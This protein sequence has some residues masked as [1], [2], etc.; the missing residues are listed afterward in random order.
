[1]SVHD[2]LAKYNL[3][4]NSRCHILIC[5]KCHMGI[6]VKEVRGHYKAENDSCPWTKDQVSEDLDEYN[7]MITSS[8]VPPELVNEHPCEPVQGLMLHNGFSCTVCKLSWPAKKTMKNHFSSVHGKGTAYRMIN[9]QA[10]KCQTFYGHVHKH[11]FTVLP[12]KRATGVEA[13]LPRLRSPS[14]TNDDHQQAVHKMINKLEEHAKAEAVVIPEDGSRKDMANWIF[15]TG[16]YTYVEGLIEQGKTYHDMVVACD[17]EQESVEVMVVYIASWIDTVMRRLHKTG[18]FLKRLCMAE[19]R[20]VMLHID[21]ED[22]KGMMPLQEKTSVFKYARIIAT[23]IWFLVHQVDQGLDCKTQLH[24]RTRQQLRVLR[25]IVST[26]KVPSSNTVP[27]ERMEFVDITQDDISRQV[28]AILCAIFQVRVGG[29][30]QQYHFPPMQFL[31][32]GRSPVAPRDSAARTHFGGGP[33]GPLSRR[34]APSHLIKCVYT[35]CPPTASIVGMVITR[36]HCS[37]IVCRLPWSAALQ[38]RRRR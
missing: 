33:H 16:I 17:Q 21:M 26:K 23:F 18:Q 25:N 30:V 31:A 37:R 13:E 19:T 10:A 34:P 29:Y 35:Q 11:Y 9:S 15:T 5:K 32:T 22:N 4:W 2:K 24:N 12:H 27:S 6:P 8:N 36:M 1:M 3:M 38:V 7:D 28:S 14:P 20:C